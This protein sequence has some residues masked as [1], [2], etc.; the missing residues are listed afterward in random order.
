MS[1]YKH[2][3]VL[4]G[5]AAATG[6][7]SPADMEETVTFQATNDASGTTTVVDI[8]V[9]NDGVQWIVMGTI[10]LAANNETDGFVSSAPWKLVRANVTT[11]TAGTV[12]VTM[13]V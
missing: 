12:T 10:S 13:G 3:V 4:L 11:R 8:E 6:A 1:K 5:A 2:N 9:S 7:G